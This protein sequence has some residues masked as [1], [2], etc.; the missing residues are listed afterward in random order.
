MTGVQTCALPISTG[1][2]KIYSNIVADFFLQSFG[3]ISFLIAVSL[4]SWGIN[5]MINK[6]IYNLLSKVFYTI[7]YIN[8]GCLFIYLTNNNSFWLIDNGNSGFIGEQSFDVISKFSP[9]IESSF[10]KVCLLLL[11][12]IFFILGSGINIKL[13]F[14]KIFSKKNDD[15]TKE[16]DDVGINANTTDQ[17]DRRA[18]V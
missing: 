7:L 12:L 17:P 1:F 4:L 14:Q 16:M 2:F 8:L 15:V 5:L 9:L 10:S 11:T 6:K 3:L 13:I 18:H